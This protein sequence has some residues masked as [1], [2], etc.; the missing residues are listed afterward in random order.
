MAFELIVLLMLIKLSIIV[1]LKEY[2]DTMN[3]TLKCNYIPKDIPNGISF[4][5]ILDFKEQ[6]QIFEV[7]SSHF[8]TDN[9]RRVKSLELTYT[10]SEYISSIILKSKCF[11]GLKTLQ[12]LHIHLMTGIKLD[13]NA[14]TGLD[15]LKLLDMSGCVRLSLTAL[16]R[17]INGKGILP[18]LENLNV[19]YLNLYRE[20]NKFG[21]KLAQALQDKN[22]TSLDFSYTRISEINLTALLNSMKHLKNV[23]ISHCTVS[24]VTID[25]STDVCKF[26]H[27]HVL[28]FSHTR[29]LWD[30]P[31]QIKIYNKI[32]HSSDLSDDS[33]YIL[34][35]KVVNFSSISISGS[36]QLW[37][38]NSTGQVNI[39]LEW[40]SQELILRQNNIKYL[41]IQ[42]Q[43]NIY[44]A[45]T[46]KHIDLAENGLEFLHPSMTACFPNLERIDLSRNQLY[47]MVQEHHMF[48][49]QLY[50]SL[51]HLKMIKLSTNF[52]TSIPKDTFIQNYDLEKIDLS[53][54]NLGQVTFTLQHL[55]KLKVLDLR[56]NRIKILNG[57]SMNNLESMN[58][59]VPKLGDIRTSV[60]LESNPISCSKCEAKTFIS[61][62]TSTKSVDIPTSNLRC[63]T[64]SGSTQNINYRTPELVQGI[65]NKKT[66]IISISTSVGLIAFIAVVTVTIT[67]KCK[68][69]ARNKAKRM[70]FLMNLH[71]GQGQYEFAAFLSHSSDDTDFVEN[72][73]LDK[74]N[75]NLQLMTGIDR[76]LVCTGDAY[77]RPGFLI[78]D[79]AARCIER[80][81]A[82][83]VVVSD[84]YCTS[85]Y[86]HNEIDLAN[87]LN[88]PIILMIKGH[89]D[90]NLM[91]PTMKML[92]KSN[93]RV[94]WTLE[95]NEYILKTTW[96][97]VC[98]SVLDLI[99][100][101]ENR[102]LLQ[103]ALFRG[104]LYSN[105]QLE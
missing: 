97:N 17:S 37:I 86:C 46:F 13:P 5:H 82:F 77:L 32:W 24:H 29:L 66:V 34:S 43:C 15:T 50:V 75:E 103:Q 105:H 1:S 74:L 57:I 27:L 44:A 11:H 40:H 63:I 92:F 67:Y 72:Y 83:I 26:M 4:V 22:V 53:H 58:T 2:Y 10:V 45:F 7:N 52:L 80:A 69:W 54:N 98:A 95:N 100:Q 25:K 87:R 79:E 62:L 36:G 96:E 85:A 39:P 51:H 91:M 56:N 38:I 84:S 70:K 28:D 35:P 9:W 81:S 20:P 18:S 3:T 48:F 30:I 78:L 94:L 23:N 101:N 93:V 41:D 21:T 76:N 99:A 104:Q 55:K 19:S 12:E 31:S 16:V 59:R 73:L 60:Q 65:C 64:E 68:K 49:K 47:K 6:N 14:F 71:A 61:W 33:N 89:V 102:E 8:E 88:K 90:E 42:M